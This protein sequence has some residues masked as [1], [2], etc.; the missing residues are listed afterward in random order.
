MTM[1]T[2]EKWLRV[3]YKHLSSRV[4]FFEKVVLRHGVVIYK[5][6][7]SMNAIFTTNSPLWIITKYQFSV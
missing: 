4:K 3:R 1:M 2:R 5:M 6:Q 7:D